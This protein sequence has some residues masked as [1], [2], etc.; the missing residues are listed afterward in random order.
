MFLRLRLYPPLERSCNQLDHRS[1]TFHR[2]AGNLW[3]VDLGHLLDLYCLQMLTRYRLHP[4]LN[5]QQAP[6][7]ANKFRLAV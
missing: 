7:L 4:K 1:K 3:M 6:C 2:L 5:S